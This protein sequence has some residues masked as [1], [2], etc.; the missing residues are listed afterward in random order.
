M[1]QVMLRY[2]AQGNRSLLLHAQR[3]SHKLGNF[4]LRTLAFR[5]CGVKIETMP[6]PLVNAERGVYLLLPQLLVQAAAIAEKQIPRAGL[7][8]CHWKFHWISRINW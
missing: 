1:L 6:H 3:V 8:E 5:C 2:G 4:L 7:N